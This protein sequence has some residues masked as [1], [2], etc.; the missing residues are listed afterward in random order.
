MIATRPVKSKR[1][2]K[3]PSPQAIGRIDDAALSAQAESARESV[4]SWCA[5]TSMTGDG[6]AWFF[7]FGQESSSVSLRMPNR[8]FDVKKVIIGEH[9]AAD[10]ASSHNFKEA[11]ARGPDLKSQTSANLR[12]AWQSSQ[13]P[14]PPP[15]APAPAP[16]NSGGPSAG[17]KE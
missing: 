12:A 8:R 10:S 13:T 7:N 5:S 16:T 17:R 9:I 11:L 6:E 1:L 4:L 15:A 14:S 3:V 2:V